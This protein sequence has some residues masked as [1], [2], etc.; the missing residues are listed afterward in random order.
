[1]RSP[2][3]IDAFVP[4]ILAH[5]RAARAVM[6]TAAPG[7]G[8]T[9][10]VPP[11]LT[12]DGAVILLQPR[13]VAAR[14]MARRIAA[15]RGWTV[16]REV[17]WHVR[18]ERVF[19]PDTALVVATEGILTARLQQDPLLSS[20]RTIVI[21]EFHERS[22]HGDLGLALAK[23][24][25][26]A[27]EDLRIVV[28][29]ATLDAPRV[30]AFLGGCPIVDVPGREF[31]LDITYRP[32]VALEDAVV[33]LIG[34]SGATSS[35]LCFLPGA[36]EIRRAADRLAGAPALA[37]VAVLPLHGSLPGD[38]QDAALQPSGRRRVI[39]ATN[40]AE[41]TLTVPDVTTVVDTGLHKVARHDPA[42]GV[43]SLETERITRDSADQ[44]AGRAGRTGPG[45]AVRLWDSRDRLRPHREPVIARV[46]VASVVLDVLV[47]GGDP[48]TFEWFEAPRPEALATALDLL[49]RLG[50]IDERDA[51]TPLGRETGRVPLHPRLAR[52]VLAAR[53]APIAARACA[54]LS[55]R[56][57]LPARHGATTCDLFA[58]AEDERSLPAG[59]LTASRHIRDA[60]RAA[61]GGSVV[62]RIDEKS[63]RQAVLAAY[64]DRVAQRRP[65]DRERFLLA[66]GA[67]ARLARESGVHDAEFVV[68]VDVS[69]ATT[70]SS[71]ATEALIRI[72]T[73]V[74]REWLQPTASEIRYELDPTSGS[75]RATRVDRL[76][77]IALSEQPAA[78]DHAHVSPML[79]AEYL[80]RGPS[81]ADEQLLRRLAF[82]GHV[83]EFGHLVRMAAEAARHLDD[84]RL[85]DHVPADLARR[86][87]AE[88]P[89]T[90]RLPSGR[91]VRLD[92]RGN[93]SVVASVKIQQVFGL[94]ASPQLGPRRVPVTFELLAPNGRPAQITSDLASFWQR[95][96]PEVRKELRAR[97]PKHKW[98]EEP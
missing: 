78:A 41:T 38:E 52:L 17:G 18:Q 72:A 86:L 57:F 64:P 93:G 90:L 44:R 89:P 24:A 65:A 35:M 20:F 39:L 61:L 85:A 76:G 95:G 69:G 15:E 74:E 47:W 37:G 31:P 42:R 21:D 79:A 92:Y 26:I 13:R 50:A 49:R 53:G 6:V 87:H 11:A 46:D 67:G 12:E 98:P 33:D 68:A 14:A 4:Q 9:T 23:Q 84:I 62:D 96:Y 30:A 83:I 70:A 91:D 36:P 32:G 16:G 60:A 59:V 29:S 97:Y 66:S 71:A 28:M 81:E 43:D 7:A 2:L 10:R 19:A 88:A 82:A 1:V 51:L 45:R 58:A 25:W 22:I 56:H 75:V 27:R 63:F 8:K 80:R 77:A 94:K 48:R 73:R 5:A 40:I 3:P 55:E 54:L 34:T